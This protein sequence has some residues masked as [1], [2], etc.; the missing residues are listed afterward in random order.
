MWVRSRVLLVAACL[1][2]SHRLT[3]RLVAHALT[4]EICTLFSYYSVPSHG[5]H[6]LQL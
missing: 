4:Y 3:A 5:V 1:P 6:S 2:F